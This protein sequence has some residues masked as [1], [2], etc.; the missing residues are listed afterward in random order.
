[1]ADTINPTIKQVVIPLTNAP[2]AI[3]QI[4]IPMSEEN[5]KGLEGFLTLIKEAVV[6]QPVGDDDFTLPSK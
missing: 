4:P 5:W 1:M 2:W 6:S 3:L